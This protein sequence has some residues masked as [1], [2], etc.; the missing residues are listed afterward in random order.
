MSSVTHS[1]APCHVNCTSE[2]VKAGEVIAVGHSSHWLRTPQVRENGWH[3]A[4][5][6]ID[7]TIYR[8]ECTF[9]GG[10]EGVWQVVD[11]DRLDRPGTAYRVTLGPDG[12]LCDCPHRTY[13][14]VAC[15]HA[16]AVRTA[17]EWLE[18]DER[19]RWEAA[20]ALAALD[21]YHR[22]PAPF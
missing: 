5:L 18:E 22:E 4:I 1:P 6:S 14:G 12:D 15:K 21:D 9:C 16:A 8:A 10:S 17:L 3:H 13:R 11:L 20:V 2:T 7:G 19:L